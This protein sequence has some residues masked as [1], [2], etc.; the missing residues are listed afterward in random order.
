MH[1]AIT[2]K[3]FYQYLKCPNW[4]YLDLHAFEPRPHEALLSRLQD[5]GLLPEKERELL[6]D[7]QDTAEVTAE[8]PD[9]AFTQTLAF[10]REG[11]HTI[12]HGVLVDKHWVGHPDILERVEGQSRL[13]HYYYVAADLKRT[14]FVRDDHK[15]Q[16]CFYAELLE[17]VQGVKPV[18]GYVMTPDREVIPYLI[19]EFEAQ[20]EITLTE[21]EKIVAGKRPAHFVTSG[22][23]QS[24]WFAECR[25]ESEACDD[26][27]LL[28]RVWREEV[29]RL[30][31]AGVTTIGALALRSVPDLER[32]CPEVSST[33]LEIMRDQAIAIK[34]G[35]HL[36]RGHV[37]MP[38]ARVELFFDI[39][40]DPL[41]DF[42]YLL[43]VLEV[44]SHGEQYHSFFAAAPEQEAQMWKEFVAF[45]EGHMDAPI[46]HYGWFER[47]VVERFAARY[48][49][50]EI[51]RQA[52]QENMLD[53]LDLIRPAVIFPLSFYSLKDLGAY[54]GF[55]WRS[56]DASGANSVLWFEEWL[57]KKTPKLLQ[58]ILEY[59]EDDV[60]ATHRLQRWVREH[61]SL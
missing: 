31:E 23:K 10:M 36:I 39:E 55:Q 13:G 52:L 29:H 37:Q 32:L 34:E 15:F 2:E 54:I 61:A 51:A 33:R 14:R 16:G 47:E 25:S 9:E 53:L 7:R 42:D 28:N 5:D 57:K 59:N 49:I 8:D 22:C 38:E 48:G 43:G 44:T 58:K 6:T 40:S 19:E 56:E 50:S 1:P 3:T 26:L 11:R 17:R 24:P 20:Y 60:R 35:R 21:I 4:V 18:Q 45:I 46:Y 12:Y 30:E 27:S 41:R